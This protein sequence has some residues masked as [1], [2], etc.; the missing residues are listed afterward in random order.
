MSI[1]NI[2]YDYLFKLIIIGDSSVGK[3]CLLI[4]YT[5]NKF[6][7]NHIA[8]IGVDFKIKNIQ[9]ENSLIKLQ[10]WDTAGSS[11]YDALTTSYYRGADG[12]VLTFDL[13]NQE[14]FD[15]LKK[16]MEKLDRY[17][18]EDIPKILIGTKSDLIEARKVKYL[19]AL[20]FS[21]NNEIPYVETSSL[22]NENIDMAFFN[23][24]KKIKKR[25]DRNKFYNT[26]VENT[27]S[28]ILGNTKKINNCNC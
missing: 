12:V 3:S 27:K 7:D 6:Y 17:T 16:W 9:L 24:V 2:D 28:I 26:N 21:N 19:D 23:L 11:R 18:R 4:R 13:T 15:N 14:S 5:E 22:D 8:T 10:I 1:V 25:T 20:E